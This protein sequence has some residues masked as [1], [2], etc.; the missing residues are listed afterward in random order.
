MV[1]R[2]QIWLVRHG[3]TEWSASGQ[4]TGRTDIPLTAPGRHQ[5]EALGRRLAGRPFALVLTSPLSRARETCQ[6]AG[7]GDVAQ[8]TNDLLEW[9]YGIYEGRTTADVSGAE[10]GWSIWTTTIPEGETVEQVGERARRVIGRAAAASGEVALF[11][12]AH[13]LR[14]LAACWI[15]QPPINGRLFALGTASIS[16]LGY[17]RETRVISAWNMDWCLGPEKNP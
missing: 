5:A 17:E 11:A 1:N 8:V 12:H 13:I 3:D 15:G 2:H 9:N 16:I 4:H 7:Y 6:L 14:I 10:P